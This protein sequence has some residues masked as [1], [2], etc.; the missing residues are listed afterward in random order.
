MSNIKKHWNIKSQSNPNK[1]YV[2]AKLEDETFSCSCP[3]WIHHFPRKDCK[4]ILG[5]I[6]IE[7]LEL[8]SKE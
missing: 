5:V 4:H 8:K 7:E 2:V 1:L 6:M 3:A